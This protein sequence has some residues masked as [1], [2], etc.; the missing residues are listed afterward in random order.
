MLRYQADKMKERELEEIERDTEEA[1][2]QAK[3][4]SDWVKLI[5]GK[6]T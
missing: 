4:V 1:V 5:N 6:S 3:K 2:D